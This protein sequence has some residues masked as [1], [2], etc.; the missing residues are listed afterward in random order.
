MWS[1]FGCQS[2]GGSPTILAT[3]TPDLLGDTYKVGSL[4]VGESFSAIATWT[5]SDT[6]T[7]HIQPVGGSSSSQALTSDSSFSFTATTAAVH[8]VRLS[9][10]ATQPTPYSLSVTYRG[11]TTPHTNFA[12]SADASKK[13]LYLSLPSC[14]S[15]R[16]E[17]ADFELFSSFGFF[18]PSQ[19]PVADVGSGGLSYSSS[20]NFSIVLNETGTYSVVIGSSY[21]ANPY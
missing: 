13:V 19:V 11:V 9:A 12:A 14:S 5:G 21:P 18:L 1:N 10:T 15:A 6:L 3:L 8:Y 17:S 20:S 4:A 2:T 16:V 7:A